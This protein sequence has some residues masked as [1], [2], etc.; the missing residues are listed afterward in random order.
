MTHG[1]HSTALGLLLALALM[2]SACRPREA[3]PDAAADNAVRIGPENIVVA[4]T[5]TL[6]SGPTISGTLEADRAASIRAE[7]TGAVLQ[8]LAEPGQ[9]VAAG[10]LL[11]RLDDSALRDAYQSARAAARAA[12]QSLEL[13]KRNAERTAALAEAGAIAERELE[14]AQLNQANAEAQLAGAQTQLAS[15]EKQLGKT[16][17]AAP[18][19]GVVSERPINQGDIV[20]TGTPLFTVVDPTRLKLQGTVPAE[21]LDRLRV[22]TKVEFSVDGAPGQLFSGRIE[23]VNPAVDPATR[24]VRVTVTIP[25][26]GGGLV[27]GLFA[28]GRVATQGKQAVA[29]PYTAVDERGISP[30]VYRLRASKVQRAPVTLGLRDELTELVE[31]TSGVAAGDT[32]LLGSAQGI[33]EATV[34]HIAGE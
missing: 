13:A 29:V 18:F 8:V 21:D 7:L 24:Q 28:Q 10:A 23:R 14:T 11:A 3:A 6:R 2:G 17:I 16:R 4:D 12:E 31:I 34:V 30:L 25:N 27:V 19:A 20:Q 1:F 9:P 15:A 26:G 32:L 22:G 33:S 5:V